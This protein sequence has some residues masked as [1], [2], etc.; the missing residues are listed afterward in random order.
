MK[1]KV[2]RKC[3]IKKGDSNLSGFYPNDIHGVFAFRKNDYM[4]FGTK[5]GAKRHIKYIKKS[6]S[7]KD[8]Q[9]R[10]GDELSKKYKNISTKLNVVCE[11]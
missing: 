11:R 3:V 5:K 1:E 4:M 7:K 8:N 2:Y 9:N 10:W 6:I